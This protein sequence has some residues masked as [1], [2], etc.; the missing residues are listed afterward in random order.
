MERSAK[1]G[2][3]LIE[4]LIVITIIGVL[5][6]LLM[7]GLSK[8]R[9]KAKPTQCKSNLK[10]IGVGLAAYITR[11]E[12]RFPKLRPDGYSQTADSHG[13]HLLPVEARQTYRLVLEGGPYPYPQDDQVFGNREGLLPAA[14][15]G[16]YREYTVPTPGSDDRGARRL[17]VAD[18]GSAYYT[19]DHYA[20][21]REVIP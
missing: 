14:Q 7:P 13:T 10:N 15:P 20:S 17:V 5:A 16:R 19:D 9:Q 3:T 12:G 21:F 18:D 6:A 4:M 1:H 2:F 11:Y 8:A